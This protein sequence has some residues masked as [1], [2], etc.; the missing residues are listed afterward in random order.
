ML[1]IFNYEHWLE[2]REN[3]TSGSRMGIAVA[4][5]QAASL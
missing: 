3:P 1:A 2:K 5:F 4:H